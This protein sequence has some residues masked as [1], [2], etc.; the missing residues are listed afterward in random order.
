MKK[1]RKLKK[2]YFVNE[3]MNSV[4]GKLMAKLRENFNIEEYDQI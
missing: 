4:N 1:K 2:V 3:N